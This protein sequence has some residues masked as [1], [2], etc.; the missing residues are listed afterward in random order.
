MHWKRWS[1][2]LILIPPLILLILK[3][4]PILYAIVV[5]AVAL[6]TLWEFY[7]IVF[8]EHKTPVPK[9]L[10]GWGYLCGGLMVAAVYRQ[11]LLGLM[12]ILGANLVGVAVYSIMRFRTDPDAPVVAVKAVFGLVYIPLL[13]C[14]L[15][16]LRSGPDGPQWVVFLLWVVAW[17]DTGAF[18]TGTF[19]GRHKLCPEVSPKKTVEGALGGLAANLMAAWLFKW[20]FFGSMAGLSCTVLSLSAGAAGQAGDLFESEF[21]RVSGIKDSSNLLPGHGGF[22]D[23]LDA[24]LFALPVV[25]LLK[26]YCLP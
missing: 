6:V 20:M 23:R 3:G 21:K 4:S 10:A 12:A 19:F 26:E 24:L 18:Y 15:I 8:H 17:G 1:T 5:A 13:L 2:A 22:L 9:L 25:F 7:H 16:P 11:Q 14:F